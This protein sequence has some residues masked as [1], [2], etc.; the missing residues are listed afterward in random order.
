[1]ARNGARSCAPA[2]RPHPVVPRSSR[3]E[4]PEL[5]GQHDRKMNTRCSSKDGHLGTS[6]RP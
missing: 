6:R 5:Q 2:G 4:A 3:G 1:M